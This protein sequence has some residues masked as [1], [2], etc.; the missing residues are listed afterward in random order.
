MFKPHTWELP[1]DSFFKKVILQFHV[2][3]LLLQTQGTSVSIKSIFWVMSQNFENKNC[4]DQAYSFT[5][6]LQML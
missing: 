6:E 5:P 4:S 2:Y 3:V 1:G